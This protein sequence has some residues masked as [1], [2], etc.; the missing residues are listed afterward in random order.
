MILDIKIPESLNDLTLLQWQKISKVASI[1][2]VTELDIGIKILEVVYGIPK[3]YIDKMHSKDITNLIAEYQKAIDNKPEFK[4]KFK[5]NDVLYGFIPNLDEITAGE[6]IDIDSY[7]KGVDSNHKLMSILY[8]PIIKQSGTDYEVEKY[9]G[10]NGNLKN[11]SLGIALAA[12]GF[13]LTLGNELI[14]SIVA[15]LRVENPQLLNKALRKSG[16]GISQLTHL[17]GATF[18]DMMKS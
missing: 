2:N 13:F 6:L 17:Q 4:S 8:R 7:S 1:K 16:V 10:A 3:D 11:M 18:L 5:L 12:Q 14:Q 15:S 9:A